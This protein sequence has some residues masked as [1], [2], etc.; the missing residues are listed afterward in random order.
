[1]GQ[2]EEKEDTGEKKKGTIELSD[3]NATNEQKIIF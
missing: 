3:E 2:E 1:M